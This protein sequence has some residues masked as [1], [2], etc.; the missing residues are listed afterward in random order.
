[1]PE[2]PLENNFYRAE[3]SKPFRSRAFSYTLLVV[4]HKNLGC[5]NISRKSLSAMSKFNNTFPSRFEDIKFFLFVRSEG[6]MLTSTKVPPFRTYDRLKGKYNEIE[7][8]AFMT[9][10]HRQSGST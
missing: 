7:K 4:E 8:I 9:P 10:F 3:F 2:T 5:Q 1:M 6:G